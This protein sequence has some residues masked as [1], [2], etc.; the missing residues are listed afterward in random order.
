MVF[1]HVPRVIY[2]VGKGLWKRRTMLSRQH[3]PATTTVGIGE[4]NKHIYHARLGLFD[5]D[6]LGH[7]NNG[8]CVLEKQQK[9]FK[10]NSYT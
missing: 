3:S 1:V 9:G 7:M 8:K 5:I 4:T 2:N 10:M 6:Y